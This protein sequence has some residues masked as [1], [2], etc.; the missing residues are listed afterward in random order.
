MGGSAALV[1]EA[2]SR[3]DYQCLKL[4]L[5]KGASPKVQDHDARRMVQG[6]VEHYNNISLNSA[7]GYITPKDMLAW[8]SASDQRRE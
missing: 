3:G 6:Y 8:A 7:I 2:A 1:G 5:D 4:I